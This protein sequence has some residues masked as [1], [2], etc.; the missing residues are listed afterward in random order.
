M[1]PAG[2]TEDRFVDPSTN[3]TL[4]FEEAWQSGLSV[5]VPG[6]PKLMDTMH[7]KF[8]ILEWAGLFDYAKDLAINGYE[9]S[10]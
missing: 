9:S 7:E 4:G 10:L 8:G 5:G 6:V 2:A 1:A 3:E